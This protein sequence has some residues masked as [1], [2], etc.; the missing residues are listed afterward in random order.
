MARYRLEND[1]LQLLVD[2]RGAEMKS[3]KNKHTGQEYLWSGDAAYWGRTAPVLFPLV[4]NYRDKTSLYGGKT[5][6]MGQHGFARDLEFSLLSQSERELWFA[7]E[8]NKTTLLSYPFRFRLVLGYR[9]TERG[10][11]AI[12]RVEN[13][14]EQPMYFSIGGHPAF[15]CPLLPG[16]DQTDCFLVFDTQKPLVSQILNAR[17]EVSGREKV[18]ETTD[19][20]LRI[21]AT[22]FDEDALILEGNQTRQIAL[23]G[24]DGQVYLTVS[25]D[26]PLVGIWSPAKKGAPFVCIEPWYGRSDRADFS[27]K[28]EEREY[29]NRLEAGGEFEKSYHIAIG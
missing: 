18:L 10:V 20:R 7:L 29:S 17:G 1:L 27:Q 22:L 13:T 16:E 14:N 28:L 25:F 6:R 2:T 9:L 4:G 15:N 8:E 23:A 11:T 19:G 26:A 3:L 21:P 24:K 5:Y 12:W